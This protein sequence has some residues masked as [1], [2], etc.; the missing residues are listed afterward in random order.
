MFTK[1]GVWYT[2]IDGKR[3]SLG[4]RSRSVAERLE[5]QLTGN[6]DTGTSPRPTTRKKQAAPRKTSTIRVDQLLARWL[7]VKENDGSA[8]MTV[9]AYLCATRALWRHLGHLDAEE[10]TRADV[11]AYNAARRASVRTRNQELGI[12]LRALRWGHDAG[13]IGSAPDFGRRWAGRIREKRVQVLSG[14]EY[15][16]LLACAEDRVRVPMLLGR[17]CGLRATEVCSLR[18][19][20]VN[21]RAAQLTVRDSKSGD[22]V[23][24]IPKLVLEAL[25]LSRPRGAQGAD[26]V[27]EMN[28]GV[29]W[30][31]RHFA[32]IT[33][34]AFRKAGLLGR[35][36]TFHLLR[37]SYATSFSRAGSLA[38]LQ[39]VLGHQDLA[40]SRR[41]LAATP[42]GQRAGMEAA[43][44]EM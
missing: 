6:G 9:K 3:V 41:Y 15:R 1:R 7:V 33:S 4:T 5:A 24:P 26:P 10:I 35:G 32:T 20:H 2:R 40:A 14:D 37:A 18:W 27:C 43:A 22:R 13:L 44:A 8:P 21:L 42:E 16:L 38:D 23:V 11:D 30:T 29:P 36:H 28:P 39:E 12:L 19:S 17:G 25:T 34:R 31:A